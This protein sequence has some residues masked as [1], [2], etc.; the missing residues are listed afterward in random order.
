MALM[1]PNTML[2]AGE[3]SIWVKITP[4]TQT[5]AQTIKPGASDTVLCGRSAPLRRLFVPLFPEDT[6][7]AD[8]RLPL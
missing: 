5:A 2:E 1:K 3:R 4:A 7:S 6:S 8:Q